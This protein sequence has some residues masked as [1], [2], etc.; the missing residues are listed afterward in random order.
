MHTLLTNKVGAEGSLLSSVKGSRAHHPRGMNE[1]VPLGSPLHIWSPSVLLFH[2]LWTLMLRIVNYCNVL[3]L[4]WGWTYFE[5]FVKCQSLLFFRVC[6]TN[7]PHVSVIYIFFHHELRV[8][9][10]VGDRV[11]QHGAKL[12]D[13]LDL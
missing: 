7:Q 8:F 11:G 3:L 6:L 4:C 10:E 12:R 9:S 2:T 13:F 5:T 1:T